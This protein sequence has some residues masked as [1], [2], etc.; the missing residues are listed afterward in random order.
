VLFALASA[1]GKTGSPPIHWEDD[2]DRGFATAAAEDRPVVMFFGAS[3]DASAKE[4]ERETF[5][6]P[7]VR[8]ELQAFVAIH[9]DCTDTDG[10]PYLSAQRRFAIVGTPTLIFFAPGGKTELGRKYEYVTPIS[11]RALL[12]WSATACAPGASSCRRAGRPRSRSRRRSS[13]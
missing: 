13:R 10:E 5:G 8:D 6:D 4:I 1:C 2:V 7:R 11:M 12:Q 3:W 9:V